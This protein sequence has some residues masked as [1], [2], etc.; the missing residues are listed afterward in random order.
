[1]KRDSWP[2][3]ALDVVV[4]TFTF[5]WAVYCF[6]GLDYPI[7]AALNFLAAAVLTRT[8]V[9]LYRRLRAR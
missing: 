3:F 7:V 8:T 9:G 6:V 1:M 4:A 5:G 2:L